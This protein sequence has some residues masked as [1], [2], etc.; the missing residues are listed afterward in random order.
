[1]IQSENTRD[2]SL[3]PRIEAPKRVSSLKKSILNQRIAQHKIGS[4]PWKAALNRAHAEHGF[5]APGDVLG[6]RKKRRRTS[7]ARDQ[8]RTAKGKSNSKQPAR[9]ERQMLKPRVERAIAELELCPAE[10]LH[11]LTVVTAFATSL[12][13]AKKQIV[14]GGLRLNRFMRRRFKH[15]KWLLFSEVDQLLSKDVAVDILSDPKWKDDIPGN[16]LLYKVHFHG[17]VFVPGM[18]SHEVEAAFK[19]TESGK[20]SKLYRGNKQVRV[21]PV[22]I[23][24]DAGKKTPDVKGVVGYSTKFFFKPPVISRMFE[25]YPEWVDLARFIKSD[26]RSTLIGGFDRVIS[27][28]RLPCD[29]TLSVDRD[30]DVNHTCGPCPPLGVAIPDL[31]PGHTVCEESKLHLPDGHAD[32]QLSWSSLYTLNS[33]RLTHGVRLEKWMQKKRNGIPG[34]IARCALKLWRNLVPARGP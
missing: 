16:F 21:I 19:R 8:A 20:I 12:D 5:E 34:F 31:D 30:C 23:V 17:P 10:N 15:A 33:E 28:D 11:F 18:N 27:D 3:G 7:T 13:D 29:D 22:R 32:P 1:M 25:G 26:S 4:L 9:R 2:S 24:E 6:V 14:E